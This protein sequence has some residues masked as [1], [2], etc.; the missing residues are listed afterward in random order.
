MMVRV[1]AQEL[2]SRIEA[3][4]DS[5]L[6]HEFI[7]GL[8]D[9]SL[10]EES[11]QYYVIQDSYYL[12]GFARALSLA[13]AKAPVDEW[14]ETFKR[15]ASEALEV[16]RQLHDSFFRDLDL[17]SRDLERTPM[18]PITSAY[19]NYLLAV[20]Y[21]RPF[22]EV[23]G[24]LLPCYWVYAEVGKALVAK[25][26]TQPLYQRWIDT[27]AGE[28]YEAVVEDVLDMTERV[29]ESADK[30]TREAMAEHFVAS[31]RYEWMFWDSAYR[32][33]SWPI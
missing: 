25:G 5:I 3:I 6:S 31:T 12:R 9:G 14:A 19:T 13:S 28:E 4:Y 1:F 26:S 24:V 15:N 16:E 18:A 11:F 33:E 27:Y 10:P 32:R 29:A 30:A 21:G 7:Q 20:A 23:V 17:T 2:W 8:T 22:A